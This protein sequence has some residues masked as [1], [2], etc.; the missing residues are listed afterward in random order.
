VCPSPK[1]N[2]LSAFRDRALVVRH[3]SGV[4]HCHISL[5]ECIS[6]PSFLLVVAATRLFFSPTGSPPPHPAGGACCDYRRAVIVVAIIFIVTTA[7]TLIFTV[8][9]AAVPGATNVDDD[10]VEAI[11]ENNVTGNI[12]VSAIGLAMAIVALLGARMY[13]IPMLA[14]NVVWFLVSYAV[15]VYFTVDNFNKLNELDTTTTPYRV[16]VGLLVFQFVVT[17]LWIY[18]FVFLIKEIKSGIMSYETYPREEHSCC[19]VDNRRRQH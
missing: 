17:C 13:S 19:C 16:P 15:S 3:L 10:E 12:I 1:N 9:G 5:R 18:P 4:G 2:R 6:H 7:L 14:L 11:L 8:A